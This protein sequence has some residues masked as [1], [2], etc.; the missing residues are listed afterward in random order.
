MLSFA[1]FAEYGIIELKKGSTLLTG[2]NIGDAAKL[3]KIAGVSTNLSASGSVAIITDY[4]YGFINSSNEITM[5]DTEVVSTNQYTYD[6]GTTYET[7]I[8]TNTVPFPVTNNVS[9]FD[10]SYLINTSRVYSLSFT[11]GF[12]ETNDLNYIISGGQKILCSGSAFDNGR[13][14]AVFER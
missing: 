1:C 8:T 5:V 10:S 9:Y 7:V 4:S 11:G 12:Y 6:G 2:L 3:C 13:I 14:R